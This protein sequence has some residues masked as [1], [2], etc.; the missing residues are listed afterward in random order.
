[1]SGNFGRQQE[2][3]SRKRL[4]L[5][6]GQTKA[7]S[8]AIQN[9]LEDQ[10]SRLLE[11][12]FLFPVAGFLRTEPLAPTRTPGHMGLMHALQKNPLAPPEPIAVLEAEMAASTFQTLVLS[13]ESLFH[14]QPEAAIARLGT[15]FADFDITVVAVLRRQDHWL[16]SRY[17]EEVLS[18]FRQTTLTPA[19]FAEKKFRDGALDYA[20]RLVRIATAVQAQAVR[21][22]D[23]DH[24]VAGAGLI[25]AFLDMAGLPETRQDLAR[26]L[27][28]NV[29]PKS[30]VLVEGAR[31]LNTLIRGLSRPA[32]LELE[33]QLRRLAT[34]LG[35]PGADN[36]SAG[37]E[38]LPLDAEMCAAISQSNIRLTE[39]FRVEPPV[40]TP[41]PVKVDRWQHRRG[42]AAVDRLVQVGLRHLVQLYQ[43][44]AATET[45]AWKRRSYPVLTCEGAEALIDLL[46]APGLSLHLDSPDT[47][48]M[49]AFSRGTM[50]V[51]LAGQR[52]HQAEISKV[53]D[54]KLPGEIVCFQDRYRAVSEFGAWRQHRAY[55]CRLILA[56][57][58]IP[59]AHLLS[60]WRSLAGQTTRYVL[61]GFSFRTVLDIAEHLHLEIQAVTGTVCVLGAR[62][63]RLQED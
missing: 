61:P 7:G 15:Y 1:M 40:A 42:G 56:P 17:L 58:H 63:G 22:M 24:A 2:A 25:P 29:S 57:P 3:P 9:Y 37:P 41:D 32:R 13:S 20:E 47:A 5:H 12:G 49:A 52:T 59:V 36:R 45:G 46:A 19:D 27:R 8:T 35:D 51:L 16:A 4:I 6:V 23:Y 33:T 30:A 31:R 50:P 10:R 14:D 62:D 54:L 60:V 26:S 43:Q 11:H 21:A 34:E 28:S 38:T 18:G 53:L 48:V 39:A 44:D 55:D